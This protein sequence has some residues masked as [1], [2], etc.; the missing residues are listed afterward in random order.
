MPVAD[1]EHAVLVRLDLGL[2]RAAL[3]RGRIG[4]SAARS[5]F[6]NLAQVWVPWPLVSALAGMSTN[7]ARG[8]CLTCSSARRSSGGLMKSSAE[9]THSTGTVIRLSSA[10]GS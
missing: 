3:A 10:A 8:I 6:Q 5:A 9:L 1:I 4:S 2:E 7:F